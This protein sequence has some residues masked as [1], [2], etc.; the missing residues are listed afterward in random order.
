M[1]L[2]NISITPT[3]LVLSD[4]A[5]ELFAKFKEANEADESHY[6]QANAK[7]SGICNSIQT[8]DHLKTTLQSYM[9]SG[10]TVRPDLYKGIKEHAQ[11]LLAACDNEDGEAHTDLPRKTDV[12]EDISSKLAGQLT[13]DL[14]GLYLCVK[15]NGDHC[16][17]IMR[18]SQVNCS[19]CSNGY[20]AGPS[21]SI[22]FRIDGHGIIRRDDGVSYNRSDHAVVFGRFTIE[23]ESFDST[24]Y[25]LVTPKQF[26]SYITKAVQDMTDQFGLGVNGASITS[27]K[28]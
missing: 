13:Q 26:H 14:N 6:Y 5:R 24:K 21:Y 22:R 9:S 25:G 27:N 23:T 7:A 2:K 8:L 12:L 16:V 18:V 17:Y 15:V 4:E 1:K 3:P 19:L 11:E 10:N 28:N 20:A